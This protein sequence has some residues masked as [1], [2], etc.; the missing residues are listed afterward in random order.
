VEP[1]VA[2]DPTQ[3]VVLRDECGHYLSLILHL[4]AAGA[5]SSHIDLGTA[6]FAACGAGREPWI[7]DTHE[8]LHAGFSAAIEF[9]QTRPVGVR[10][11]DGTY[12]AFLGSILAAKTQPVA[13]R[14]APIRGHLHDV[15]SERCGAG[16]REHG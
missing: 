10:L 9:Y 16:R 12:G 14:Q 4:D 2:I 11:V 5:D 1:Q 8:V 15:R 6:D 3:F 7:L 13:I